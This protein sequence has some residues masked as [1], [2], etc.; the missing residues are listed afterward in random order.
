[1]LRPLV[2]ASIV[3][4][5]MCALIVGELVCVSTIGL[6][7]RRKEMV[8]HACC[9]LIPFGSVIPAVTHKLI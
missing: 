3:G 8:E 2:C 9:E 4:V 1:M 7:E 6:L 5:L